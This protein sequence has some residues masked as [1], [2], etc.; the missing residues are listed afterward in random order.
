MP[1]WVG[2]VEVLQ[3]CPVVKVGWRAYLLPRNY[4][5]NLNC[6]QGAYT[7]L[8][9]RR[10]GTEVVTGCLDTQGYCIVCER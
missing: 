6:D 1:V 7:Q 5:G 2:D 9:K 4:G 10:G 8:E 3:N